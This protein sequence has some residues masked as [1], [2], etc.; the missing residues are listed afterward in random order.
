MVMNLPLWDSW[1]GVS[2]MLNDPEFSMNMCKKFIKRPQ[3]VCP[4]QFIVADIF[5]FLRKAADVYMEA[6]CC[7]AE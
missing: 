3:Q 2:R 1:Y 5:A 4:K 6:S 7:W